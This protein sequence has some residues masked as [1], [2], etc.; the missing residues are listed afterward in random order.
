M[1]GIMHFSNFFRFMEATEHAFFRSLG[2]GL[3]TNEA[4]RMQG[5]ARVHAEC[6][7]RRPAHYQDVLEIH[8]RVLEK[9]ESSLAYEFLFH[10]VDDDS[11]GAGEELARG[12]LKV[13]CVQR[14]DAES[15]MR[16]T[17]MPAEVA[18]QVHVAPESPN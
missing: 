5:W 17:A 8:L 3:H 12:G 7:Y 2:L 16:A 4:G 10:R 6:D 15:R 13:V 14:Q 1:A 11:K 9:T 18:Q